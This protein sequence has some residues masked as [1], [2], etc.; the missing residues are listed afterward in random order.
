MESK[1]D[2]E[3]MFRM[4]QASG[5]VQGFLEKGATRMKRRRIDIVTIAAALDDAR[6][7]QKELFDQLDYLARLCSEAPVAEKDEDEETTQYTASGQMIRQF[8]IE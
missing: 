3:L 8:R 5:G 4:R 7:D 6:K 2:G 1:H